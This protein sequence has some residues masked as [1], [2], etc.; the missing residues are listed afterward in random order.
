MIL[1]RGHPHAVREPLSSPTPPLDALLADTTEFDGKRLRHGGGGAV[2]ELLCGGFVL[3]D[4]EVN[5]LLDAA[6]AVIQLGRENGI[7][8][9]LAALRVELATPAPGSDEMVARLADVL[10]AHAFRFATDGESPLS[11]RE[12]AAAMQLIHAHP[13]ER[14]T[15]AELARRVAL[16]RSAF[17]ERFRAVAAESPMRYL[18][19][20]R[21]G[22]AAAYLRE[23]DLSLSA[24]AERIGYES[25][26]SLA[27]AFKRDF[28]VSP[29]R[30]RRQ[31]G[32]PPE[33]DV[34]RP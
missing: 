23:S 15:V 31:R 17:S 9:I 16:S 10:V 22:L 24:I 26:S 21:L 1:L 11:D 30:F 5:P 34:T 6:P 27:R 33:I 25:E 3:Q 2:T 29:G 8:E 12:V 18:T 7:E 4:Q 13:A 19:R 32:A 14:W 28:G 20:R